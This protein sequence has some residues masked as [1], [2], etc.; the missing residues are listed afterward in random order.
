MD[1]TTFLLCL[2]SSSLTHS[3][4]SPHTSGEVLGLWS[5]S[6]FESS[7]V[8]SAPGDQSCLSVDCFLRLSLLLSSLYI[9]H[10]EWYSPFICSY[11]WGLITRA[12]IWCAFG[13]VLETGCYRVLGGG[14]AALCPAALLWFYSKSKG[15]HWRVRERAGVSRNGAWG[16]QITAAS[17]RHWG[18][19]VS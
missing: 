8:K 15:V 3:C 10:C 17:V 14:G 19:G 2:R 6:Q 18:P 12:H 9:K 16:V 7:G 11:M 4:Y 13:F 1:Y 5:T